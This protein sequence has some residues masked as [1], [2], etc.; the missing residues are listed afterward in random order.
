M[1]MADYDPD[2]DGIIAV[3]N[4]E[5]DMKKSIYDT[6]D[7]DKIDLAEN[8]EK[9]PIVCCPSDTLRKSNDS[10]GYATT[11]TYTKKKSITIPSTY[12][13]ECIIRIKFDFKV[14]NGANTGYIK[15]YKNEQPYGIEHTTSSTTYTTIT[16]E[17]KFNPGDTCE[18]WA[19]TGNV[20]YVTYYKN[21]R[22]YADDHPSPVT[23]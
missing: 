13:D 22:I 2:K 3:S 12:N 16:E 19:K 8:A 20:S 14:N 17:L 18:L 9:I 10:E 7:N 11:N 23:W 1:K 5:A 15:I 21:F 6:N 4:T